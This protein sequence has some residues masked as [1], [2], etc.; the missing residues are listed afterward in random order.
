MQPTIPPTVIPGIGV[1]MGRIV[2]AKLP[3]ELGID[4]VSPASTEPPRSSWFPGVPTTV[5]VPDSMKLLSSTTVSPST[6]K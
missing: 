1:G 2:V 5:A 4:T 3:S 6:L